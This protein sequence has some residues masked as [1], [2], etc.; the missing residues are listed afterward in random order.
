MKLLKFKYEIIAAGLIAM[1]T[2]QSFLLNN[3]GW[4]RRIFNPVINT[5]QRYSLGITPEFKGID[6][7]NN[8]L[9]NIID[10][11]GVT[12]EHIPVIRSFIEEEFDGPQL[13]SICETAGPPTQELFNSYIQL[14]NMYEI[15]GFSK[16]LYSPKDFC[17]WLEDGF[18]PEHLPAIGAFIKTGGWG[19]YDIEDIY[20]AGLTPTFELYT[21]WRQL[22]SYNYYPFQFCDLLERG[23]EYLPRVIIALESDVPMSKIE[24]TVKDN[25]G[26]GGLVE[27]FMGLFPYNFKTSE[28]ME[29]YRNGATKDDLPWFIEQC[30][31]ETV[32]DVIEGFY[33]KNG[34]DLE[35]LIL[36]KIFS[37]K[38]SYAELYDGDKITVGV[39]CQLSQD[40]EKIT[41]FISKVNPETKK[42]GLECI[43]LETKQDFIEAMKNY[44]IILF[45]GHANI[46]RG[47]NFND[48]NQLHDYLRMG[49]ETL[50][51]PSK[52][53]NKL[54]PDDKIIEQLDNG[55]VIVHG[56][57]EGLNNLEIGADVFFY[58]CCRGNTYYRGI[59]EKKYPNLEF[60]STNFEVSCAVIPFTKQLI[61]GLEKGESLGKLLK[62]INYDASNLLPEG[63]EAERKVY[64][65]SNIPYPETLV[66]N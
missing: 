6:T 40:K 25:E 12:T 24:S 11:S 5:T 35:P 9:K 66:S 18:K 29:L 45:A 23:I 39:Y 41:E 43:F 55:S 52:Y 14:K 56:G 30:K 8:S 4:A 46:G 28:I 31:Q 49:Q 13:E 15:R 59:M 48:K 2:A 60:V 54:G 16:S 17:N 22:E 26:D 44:D 65:N 38:V 63:I 57:S 62:K 51:I 42:R 58:L 37:D 50:V 1:F 61:L 7:D 27:L 34:L 20:E 19:S 32:I 53:A 10:N 21:Y 64:L 47:M 36:E 3:E 33:K